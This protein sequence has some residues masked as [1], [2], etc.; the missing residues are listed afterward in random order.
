MSGE[1]Y[2]MKQ[3]IGLVAGGERLTVDQACAAFEIMMSGDATPAQIGG[4][5]IG[6]RVRGETVDEITGGVMTMRAKALAIDA[7]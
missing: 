6:L 1:A 7:P 5:L 3:L 4:F 2:D